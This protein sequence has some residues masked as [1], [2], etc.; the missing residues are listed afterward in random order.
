MQCLWRTYRFR[1]ASVMSSVQWYSWTRRTAVAYDVA[2]G[3]PRGTRHSS[4][5]P[6]GDAPGSAG[7]S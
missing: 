3:Q 7:P 1:M 5:V 4:L 2:P 6:G